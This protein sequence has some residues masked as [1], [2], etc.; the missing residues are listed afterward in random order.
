M[1]KESERIQWDITAAEKGGY[2]HFMMKEICEQPEA[3]RKTISPRIRDGKIVLDDITLDRGTDPGHPTRCL[4]WPAARLTMWAWWQNMPLSGCLKIPLEVDVASE[5][6][7]RDPILDEKT[8]VI[9]ISQSGETADTLAA[10]RDGKGA[11]LPCAFYRQR[12]GQLPSP[13]SPTMCCIPGLVR[14]SPWLL[15]RRTALSWR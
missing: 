12:G 6:R 11:W 1:Q 10:L 15:P 7:Y 9:I 2:E 13:M 3:L 14:R 4:L 5:F 8:L